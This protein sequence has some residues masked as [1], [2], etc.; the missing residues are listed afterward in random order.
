M[1]AQMG[2]AFL[3]AAAAVGSSVDAMNKT[4]RAKKKAN[5]ALER[6]RDQYLQ[7]APADYSE[8]L[9]V[10]EQLR[11]QGLIDPAMEASILQ[12]DS[13]MRTIQADPQAK[14]AQQSALEQMERIQADGGLSPQDKYH[15]AQ[16]QDKMLG[17]ARAQQE[18]DAAQMNARGVSGSGIEVAK[19]LANQQNTAQN[20]SRETMALEAL[21]QQRR[22]AMTGQLFNSASAYR[23]QGFSE[24]AARAAAQDMIN[25]FNSG[26]MQAVAARNAN[27]D[28]QSQIANA[29]IKQSSALAQSELLRNEFGQQLTMADRLAGLE[30]QEGELEYEAGRD[31]AAAISRIG[32]GL[33]SSFGGMG[34][35]MKG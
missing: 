11:D 10:L 16:T 22:D 20:L 24:D 14:L 8:T 27:R 15:I 35:G 25:Q 9:K 32:Q 17:I 19:S 7:V 12:Q 13:E 30:K 4:A 29:G 18:A 21:A 26:N 6:A 31:Q 34:Q 2:M 23:Q 5:Q 1:G 28:L 33:N 3:G